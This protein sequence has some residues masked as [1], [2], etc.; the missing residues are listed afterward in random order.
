[1]F[2][3]VNLLGKLTTLEKQNVQR[4]FGTIVF[5]IIQL[6]DFEEGCLLGHR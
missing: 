1:M 2:H 3:V 5:L 6:T 4:D